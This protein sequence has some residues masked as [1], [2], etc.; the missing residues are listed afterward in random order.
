VDRFSVRLTRYRGAVANRLAG[1]VAW[2]VYLDGERITVPFATCEEAEYR[3]HR[4]AEIYR[5]YGW[6]DAKQGSRLR[7]VGQ[8][9]APALQPSYFARDRHLA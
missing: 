2:A 9:V 3:M 7:D 1:R 8:D 5:R 6:L 4:I